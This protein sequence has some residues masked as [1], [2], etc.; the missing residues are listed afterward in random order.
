MS[1]VEKTFEVIDH[2]ADIGIVAYGADIKQVFTNAAIGLCNLIIDTDSISETTQRDLELSSQDTESLLVEWLNELI[3][4][5]DVERLAFKSFAIDQLSNNHIKA[6]CFG[7][8]I[9][10]QQHVLKREIK[11]ATYHMLTVDKESNG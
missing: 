3:Y 5:F 4:V 6:R 7:E 10:P 9:N 11:A 2:T 1:S 8:K